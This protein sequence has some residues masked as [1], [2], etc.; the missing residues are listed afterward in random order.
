MPPEVTGGN[1]SRDHDEWDGI[2]SGLGDPCRG[3][4]ETG[5]KM[6]HKNA[7]N[8]ASLRPRVSVGGVRG[9]LFVA[10][11]DISDSALFQSIQKRYHG[12][13]AQTEYPLDAPALQKFDQLKRHKVFFH[14]APPK[15][16]N[17][18]HLSQNE[19]STD[20]RK[21]QLKETFIKWKN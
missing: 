6:R 11:G 7:R 8:L 14:D 4:R 18:T 16:S 2:Q 5:A 10:N 15:Y 9:Y 12:M 17:G 1:V 3:V 20:K 13:P 21:Q 19:F